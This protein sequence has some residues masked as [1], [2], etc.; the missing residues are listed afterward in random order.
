MTVECDGEV[1]RV[2]GTPEHPCWCVS[3]REWMPMGALEPGDELDGLVGTVKVVR[4]EAA[5]SR[6][7]VFN[8][9][10]AVAHT[11]RVSELGVVVHNACDPGA[12][13][14]NYINAKLRRKKGFPADYLKKTFGEV[15]ELAAKGDKKAK[16]V[17]KLA[18]QA[19]RLN[20]KADL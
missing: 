11:C 3:R 14:G 18:Q 8:V 6:V 7:A 19:D 13:V 5:F 12:K 2:S 1:A 16:L 20:Q 9:E 4:R 15:A 17:K 10:V